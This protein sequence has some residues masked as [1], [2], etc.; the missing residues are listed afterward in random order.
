MLRVESP[1]RLHLGQ[2]DLNGSLGRMYGGIGVALKGPKIVILAEEADELTVQG[3]DSR[4]VK[5]IARDFLIRIGIS[6]GARLQIDEA[7]P[8]H[9]G[10][11][12]S[13]QLRLAVGTALASLYSIDYTIEDIADIAL[14]GYRTDACLGIFK[15]GGFVVASG[16][17]RTFDRPDAEFCTP[18]I[19]FRD[20]TSHTS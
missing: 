7:I 3:Y 8:V 18:P 20:F 2:L 14:R 6:G 1:S 13:V 15:Y 19:I 9:V 10:L 17:P 5:A 11:G 16:I 4:R 12:S